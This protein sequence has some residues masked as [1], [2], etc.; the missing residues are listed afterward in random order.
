MRH[1]QWHKLGINPHLN[2]TCAKADL[3]REIQDCPGSNTFHR[4]EELFPFSDTDKFMG[5][6]L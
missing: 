3:I 1:L 2:R 6:I 5:I 4:Y